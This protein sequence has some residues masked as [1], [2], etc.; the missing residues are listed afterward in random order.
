[1]CIKRFTN[2]RQ[3]SGRPRPENFVSRKVNTV[4][5][6][7]VRAGMLMR[8]LFLS[9]IL[10]GLAITGRSQDPEFSQ[11]YANPLY[12]NP[13]LAG[14]ENFNRAVLNYRN[15]WPS[16]DNG[17]VTYNA[18]YDQYISKL[19]GGIG[20]LFNVDDAGDG[21]LTTTQASLMYSYT[22][23]VSYKLFFNFA[24]QGSYYQRSLNWD[25]LRFGDQIDLLNNLTMPSGEIPPESTTVRAPDFAAGV[26]FGWKSALHGGIAVHHL[27]EPN[28]AFYES[29]EDNL[30]MKITAHLGGNIN[31]EGGSM[32]FD[33][34]FY[35]SPNILY[36][37]QGM[38][39]QI[40]AGVYVTWLP[41]VLGA[42]FRHNL[43][44]PDAFI[45][46]AGIDFKNLKVGYSYD[47]TLSGINTGGAHEF[48][49]TWQFNEKDK[50][51]TI[52]PLRAPG[53]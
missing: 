43:E 7:S 39:H 27:N 38:F 33:P 32:Y 21:L 20:V 12:L 16:I 19:H 10:M 52:Y 50:M 22:L 6:E 3:F 18:S 24:L 29:R 41:L 37:Q 9:I 49:L 11:F 48:S 28:T 4:K 40:N 13:A 34:R 15:Q 35:I 23:Q 53:F 42:W 31:L 17:F 30:P 26:V 5:P 8:I 1:M 46:L 14:A 44:N 36:Q 25:M 45:L 51:R 2:C 47:M